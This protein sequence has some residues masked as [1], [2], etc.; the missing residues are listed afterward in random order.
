MSFTVAV[1]LVQALSVSYV[2][3]E[4][5]FEVCET[6]GPSML[7]TV[8]NELL[9][10]DRFT[11]KFLRY[12]EVN[13]VIIARSTSKGQNIKVCKRIIAVGGDQV[14][15]DN[16]DSRR[17]PVTVPEHMYFVH[18][19]NP[20]KSR[21][22]R[23]YGPI[24]DSSI[25]G[26]AI[27]KIWPPSRFG[28]IDQNIPDVVKKCTLLPT[29]APSSEI[30]AILD[31]KNE[32]LRT[33]VVPEVYKAKSLPHYSHSSDFWRGPVMYPTEISRDIMDKSQK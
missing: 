32:S 28:T 25:T 27:F 10:V 8:N 14:F 2:L 13:D 3:K 22:S 19:D 15:A 33:E 18:G 9:F 12:P 6:R 23:E 26:R 30:Q 31:G 24:S 11:Y 16:G 21:D 29:S 7:P 4:F 5:F 17:V 1:R 20:P